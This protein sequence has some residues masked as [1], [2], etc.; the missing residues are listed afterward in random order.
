MTNPVR[1]CYFLTPTML[2][3]LLFF[4]ENN[5]NPHWIRKYP[6]CSVSVDPNQT[7]SSD[8]FCVQSNYTYHGATF[9]SLNKQIQIVKSNGFNPLQWYR[10][11]V[12]TSAEQVNTPAANRNPT[13]IN[14]RIITRHSPANLYTGD[15]PVR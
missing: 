13:S 15:S 12:P 7:T 1:Q 3:S 8:I 14:L 9:N 4:Y 11:R 5:L 6:R 10:R 2:E